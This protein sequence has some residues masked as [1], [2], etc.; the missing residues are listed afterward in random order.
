MNLVYLPVKNQSMRI[1][2]LV[3]IFLEDYKN[4]GKSV[5]TL[6]N[7][8][9]DLKRF[10]KFYNNEDV[11]N[12]T[13]DVL[14]RYIST[15]QDFKASTR[16]R[17]FASLKSF[18]DYCC[19]QEIIEKNPIDKIDAPKIPES[20]PKPLDK[21]QID[22][23]F[24]VIP[25]HDLRDRLFFTLLLESGA[26]VGELLGILIEDLSLTMNDEKITIRGKGGYIRSLHLYSCPDSLWLMKKYLK[27]TGL[28]SGFLFRGKGRNTK[29]TYRAAEHQWQKYCEISGVQANIHQ[30]R[31][32]KA[33]SLLNQGV[34]IAV[35]SRVLG[36]KKLQTTMRYAEL[37]DH[38]IKAELL[39]V[40]Q[41]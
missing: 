19:R 8:G 39:K 5:F 38:T 16:A 13:T 32:S 31:H 18:L 10:S 33:T 28:N 24:S 22:K 11:N 25:K 26:R 29:L 2:D 3:E 1:D 37:S 7:Y 27:A 34:D 17:N 30:L 35:V 12:I 21:V 41:K 4:A 40:R 14:R 15:L 36:H 23:I 9:S 6:L 20:F